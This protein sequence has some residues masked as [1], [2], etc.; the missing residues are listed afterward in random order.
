MISA[1]VLLLFI[2]LSTLRKKIDSSWPLSFFKDL[3]SKPFFER[4]K[5][6]FPHSKIVLLLII[7][8]RPFLGA[9]I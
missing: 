7:V 9:S 5:K 1:F 6:I 4:F 8:F 2:I 3:F